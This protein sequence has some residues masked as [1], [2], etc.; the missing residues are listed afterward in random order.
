MITDCAFPAFGGI[1]SHIHYLSKTLSAM[2][3]KVYVLT[4]YSRN[5]SGNDTITEINEYYTLIKLPGNVFYQFGADISFSIKAY[6]AMKHT[7]ACIKPDIIHGHSMLS[8]L[9]YQSMYI[10]KR[11][12]I[13]FVITKHSLVYRMPE[14]FRRIIIRYL[15]PM[16]LFNK[17]IDA[18]MGVSS[19][20]LD[21]IPPGRSRQRVIYNGL[22]KEKM[23]PAR[24]IQSV[25]KDLLIAPHEH[26]IGF[27][28]RMIK[29][30]GIYDFLDTV[31]ICRKRDV[32]IK[33]VIVGD[34]PE[35]DNIIAYI[36]RMGMEKHIRITGRIEHDRIGDYFQIFDYFFLPSH[37]EGLGIVLLEAMLFDALVLTYDT[38]GTTEIVHSGKNGFIAGNSVDAAQYILRTPVNSSS[39][40]NMVRKGRNTSLQFTWDNVAQ[41]VINVYREFVS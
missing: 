24:D 15:N 2:G 1:E 33:G 39:Y 19:S 26:I 11:M 23:K 10:A 5:D 6:M 4:H 14:M 29:Q 28:S 21:E 34:G 36:R 13:P 41:R 22:D 31:N 16:S 9:V 8:M 30:K 20:V 37:S 32:S 3:H 18:Y 7:I 40:I 12:H 38:G 27:V 25:K 17:Y 35:Y